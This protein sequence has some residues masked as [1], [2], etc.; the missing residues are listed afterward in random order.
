MADLVWPLTQPQ[1]LL[2]SA[3]VYV[4]QEGLAAA[5]PIAYSAERLEAEAAGPDVMIYKSLPIRQ[6]DR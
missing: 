2:F 5:D 4:D 1:T 6:W 3:S